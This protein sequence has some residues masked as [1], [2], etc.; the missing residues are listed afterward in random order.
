MCFIHRR[1]LRTCNIRILKNDKM[2]IN[3]IWTFIIDR[4][5][6]FQH[7][8]LIIAVSQHT[9]GCEQVR[10][11]IKPQFHI[12]M[13]PFAKCHA[14]V[15]IGAFKASDWKK[16]A[17]ALEGEQCAIIDQSLYQLHT[18]ARKKNAKRQ[19]S[20]IYEILCIISIYTQRIIIAF[21]AHL[22]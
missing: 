4:Y 9:I 22:S 18:A 20:R 5:E 15:K 2:I 6:S 21:R 16:R 11:K 10:R 13:T 14:L 17:A 12:A 8:S 1:H 7:C 19:S 3:I